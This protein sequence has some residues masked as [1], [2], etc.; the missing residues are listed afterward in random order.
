LQG[1]VFDRRVQVL[2]ER[3]VLALGHVHQQ[4]DWRLV[5]GTWQERRGADLR[6]PVH[7]G[8]S[9]KLVMGVNGHRRKRIGGVPKV[10]RAHE[11]GSEPDEQ[12]SQHAHH[13]QQPDDIA[14]RDYGHFGHLVA[15]ACKR[16]KQL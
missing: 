8:Q 3:I 10:P 4:V 12:R 9:V 6:C 11:T 14:Q 7:I 1:L 16:V 15:N 2:L 13:H 5:V